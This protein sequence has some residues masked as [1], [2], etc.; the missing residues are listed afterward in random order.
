MAV[1]EVEL[2]PRQ[3]LGDAVKVAALNWR[4]QPRA[5]AA[6]RRAIRV[7]AVQPARGSDWFGDTQPDGLDGNQAR[8]LVKEFMVGTIDGCTTYTSPEHPGGPTVPCAVCRSGAEQATALWR[9]VVEAWES[10]EKPPAADGTGTA[11]APPQRR[12][13][14]RRLSPEPPA[15]VC[16]NTSCGKQIEDRPPLARYC[17]NSCRVTACRRRK[18]E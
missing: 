1:S 9:A 17:S 8:R 11:P 12:P 7:Y 14:P 13:Q 2:I 18:R 3:V 6:A 10:G 5:M 4:D 15:R 16:G